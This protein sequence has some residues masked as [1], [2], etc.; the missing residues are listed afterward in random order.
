MKVDRIEWKRAASRLGVAL[1]L[2]LTLL[3]A[4][5]C[6]P[7]TIGQRGEPPPAPTPVAHTPD[8]VQAQAAGAVAMHDDCQS[9]H[10]QENKV[11]KGKSMPTVPHQVEGWEAC[12]FCHA[13]GRIA[14]LPGRHTRVTDG[15]WM[16]CHRP[17]ATPVP[18][19]GHTAFQGKQCTSCH[20]STVALPVSHKDRATYTCELCHKAP[21]KA[22]PAVPHSVVAGV[23]CAQCHGSGKPLALPASHDGRQDQLCTTCHKERPGGVPSIPHDLDNRS[24]CTQCHVPGAR[25]GGPTVRLQ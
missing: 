24:N 20:G 9:C 12:S 17:A 10:V 18:P 1:F 15:L 11:V 21:T 25:T 4:A 7:I 5:G 3:A 23:S 22:A 8:Q 2:G 13:E 16:T 6:V 19:M 14:P